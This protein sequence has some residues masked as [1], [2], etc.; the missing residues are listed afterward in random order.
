[1]VFSDDTVTERTIPTEEEMAVDVRYKYLRIR[2][3]DE[4]QADCRELG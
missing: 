1:M 3:R 2:I 4:R